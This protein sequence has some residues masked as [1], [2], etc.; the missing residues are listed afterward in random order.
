MRIKRG[1][2]L[3]IPVAVPSQLLHNNEKR[4]TGVHSLAGVWDDGRFH[5]ARLHASSPM[6][7]VYTSVVPFERRVQLSATGQKLRMRDVEGR[8][9]SSS[10]PPTDLLEPTSKNR[11]PRRFD[12]VIDGL[13]P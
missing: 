2:A 6:A 7:R 1:K 13:E 10:A 4:R 9:I 3:E 8:A 12:F 5:P 11:T